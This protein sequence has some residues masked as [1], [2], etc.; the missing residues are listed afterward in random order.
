[1][2]RVT[3]FLVALI[4]WYLLAWPYDFRSSTMD[5]QILV[6]GLV[7]SL[8]ASLLF[9]EVFTRS[10]LKMYSPVR[11]FW[12]LC[13]LPVFFYYMLIANLD[14]VYRVVHPLMPIKPGIV[15]VRTKLPRESARTA[16]ANS[17]T[18]TPGTL[19]VDITDDGMLYVHCIYVRD[20]E[21]E[22]ATRRIVSRF[23][24]LLAR[25]FD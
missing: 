17:I 9:V 20:T 4:I 24:P 25:I 7:F 19:T 18:L 11:W 12:A 15:R 6:A 23:E 5:W 2:R 22:A 1:M 16:L 3:L 14:V 8:V 10:P 21:L 13:Y